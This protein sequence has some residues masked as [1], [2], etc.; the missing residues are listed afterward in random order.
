MRTDEI[1]NVILDP[2]KGSVSV[3][4]REAKRGEAYGELPTPTRRGYRFDGWYL[5]NDRITKDTV[6]EED[7]DVRLTARWSRAKEK[8][9]ST[10]KK[11]KMAV[12]ALSAVAVL[13]LITWAIVAQLIAIY[14]LED[15][16]TVDGKEYTER[17]TIKKEDGVYKLFDKDGT[18]MPLRENSTNV[19]ITPRSGNQYR[20]DAETGEYTL[21]AYVDPGTLEDFEAAAGTALLL[22]PEIST[23]YLYSLEV[24]NETGSYTFVHTPDGVY[25]ELN[26]ERKN[27]PFDKDLYAKLVVACGWTTATRKLT[28]AA[29]VAKLADGSIDYA[30]YGLDKPQATYRIKGVL[31]EKDAD[32]NDLYKNGKPVIDYKTVT[33]DEGNAEK[34]FREDADKD[35]TLEIGALTSSKDSYYVRLEGKESIY[36]LNGQYFQE[37]LMLPIEDIVMPQLVHVVSVNAHSM[38]NNFT[39]AKL[40]DGWLDKGYT[41][42]DADV[43]VAMTYMPLEMRQFTMNSSL[44]YANLNTTL[45]DGYRINA[46]STMTVLERFY[47][48]KCVRCVALD[49]SK[50]TMK[51]YGFDKNTLSLQ[52][53]VDQ[54]EAD[55]IDTFINNNLL[56]NTVKNENGNYYALSYDYGM[57]VEIDPYYLPFIGWDSVDWYEKYFMQIGLSYLREMNFTFGDEQYE[58]TF[59]NSLS[60]GYYVTNING[61]ATLQ[62]VDTSMGYLEQSGTKLFYKTVYGETHEVVAMINFDTVERLSYREAMKNPNKEN[63]IYTEEIYYYV[64]SD[65]KKVRVNPDFVKSDIV[66]E[67]DM[68]YFVGVV[69][70]QN[71]KIS[72]TRQF[73]EPVYRYKKGLEAIVMDNSDNMKISSEQYAG[74]NGLLDYTVN[75]PNQNDTTGETVYETVKAADNFRRLHMA[76]LFFSLEGDVNEKDVMDRYGMSVEEFIASRDA[77]ASITIKAEDYAAFL[78]GFTYD[79]DGEEVVANP[80]NNQWNVNFTFYQYTDQKAIVALRMLDENG[81]PA[82]EE[83]GR[84]YVQASYLETLHSYVKMLLNKEIIPKR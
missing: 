58:F 53:G 26:G 4:S 57:I 67:G 31:F 33:N 1:V 19:Y 52:Y 74:K 5:G 72:V 64:N 15:T 60:Y 68:L 34:Q 12:V 21:V 7:E 30:V 11:Q 66:K 41:V 83:I 62:A 45:L 8:K 13:L 42:N 3:A 54:N 27:F 75:V 76:L 10:L 81:E 9:R 37:T 79:V 38:A 50:E 14:H 39:L 29:D 82:G 36:I 46:S 59:D 61:V 78:N 69:N 47:S 70:G 22:F 6:L 71:V 40:D 77:T 2:G 65:G 44:P 73:G 17:Y 16:Y 84:F 51:K 32:G 25:I 56:I 80:K 18:L 48:L 24:E 23:S 35:F 55:G 43:I 63:I 49:I 20:I 28:K